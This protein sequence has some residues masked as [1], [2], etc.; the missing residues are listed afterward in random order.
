MCRL[1]RDRD[2]WAKTISRNQDV[3]VYIGAP[4]G[5]LAAATGYVDVDTLARYA[6]QISV[7]FSSFG[8]V[9]LWDASNAYGASLVLLYWPLGRVSSRP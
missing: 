5:P 2:Y 6:L 7:E 8:G 3:K 1:T 9:M 4:A